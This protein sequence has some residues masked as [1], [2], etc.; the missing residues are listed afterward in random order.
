VKRSTYDLPSYLHEKTLLL[1][2]NLD[3]IVPEKNS[4]YNNLFKAA[5][6]S[7]ASGGKRL[8]PILTLATAETLGSSLET[9]LPAAC[10]IEMIHTYSLIHDDLPCMDDDDFRRGKPTL[11][12]VFSEAHAVLA[13]D[14]LL[15]A[16]FEVISTAALLSA[17]QKV[18]LIALLAKSA[19][20]D[21]MIGGQIMDIESE[22]IPIDQEKLNLIHRCKTG[23]MITASIECGGIAAGASAAEIALLRLFGEEVGLAF[24]IIDDV[25]DVTAPQK[26]QRN[27]D[28]INKKVTYVSLMGLEAAPKAAYSL[29]DRALNHLSQLPHDTFLL[30]ELAH[31][32]VH[33]CS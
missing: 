21:G 30:R 8:R 26:K 3:K 33:R 23:A 24:Q 20:G 18:A 29:L 17:E 31:C 15:T 25:I 22:G 6:Y 7:M 5:R 10:A 27:S 9:A 28:Q 2:Q 1:E 12:K 13:G 32:L 19:G 16:A 14:F 11:H 4:S